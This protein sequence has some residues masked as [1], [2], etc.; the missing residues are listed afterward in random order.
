MYSFATSLYLKMLQMGYDVALAHS[1]KPGGG[2]ISFGA[3][4]VHRIIPWDDAIGENVVNV[5]HTD[6][7]PIFNRLPNKVFWAHGSPHQVFLRDYIVGDGSLSVS[8]Y[9]VDRCDLVIVTNSDYVAYWSEFVDDGDDKV[10]F[11]PGGVDL[12]RFRPEGKHMKFSG[13]PSIGYLDPIRPGLKDPFNLM[14]SMK[15]VAREVAT[16]KLVLGGISHEKVSLMSYLVGRLKLD[17]NVDRIIVGLYPQVTEIYR[18]L[19]MVVSPVVGGIVSTVAAEAMAC[20]CPAIVLLGSNRPA[21]L[22][23]KN[24]PDDMAKAIL[25][26][27]DMIEGD[28]NRVREHARGIA[29]RHYN[30]VNT[31]KAFVKALEDFFTL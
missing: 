26:L 29:E 14:I 16:A 19:D 20:G 11:V 6:I 24:N 2:E 18:G 17:M 21:V 27:W 12:D 15:K 7:P 30:I 10:R 23:C 5:I 31:V 13:K 22:K 8:A 25:R 3:L 9:L 4:G 1:A 28:R